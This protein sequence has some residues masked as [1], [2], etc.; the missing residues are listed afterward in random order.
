M[1]TEYVNKTVTNIEYS[2]LKI[3]VLKTFL[4]VDDNNIKKWLYNQAKVAMKDKTADAG[5]FNLQY[6]HQDVADRMN[7]RKWIP[8]R[9]ENK[10]TAQDLARK[11][12]NYTNWVSG[13]LL[14]TGSAMINYTQT[15]SMVEDWGV[16]LTLEAFN[17]A[18]TQ[19]AKDAVLKSGTISLINAYT[20]FMAGGESGGNMN[21]ASKPSTVVTATFNWALLKLNKSD[22]INKNTGIDKIL[23]NMLPEQDR[24]THEALR[25]QRA[26]FYDQMN[27]LKKILK[28]DKSEIRENDIRNAKISAKELR[29][30]KKR[31]KNLNGNLNSSQINQLASWM[32]TWHWNETLENFTFS[33]AELNMR[34][35]TT[36]Q[37]FI[38][39]EKFGL[40]N[41]DSNTPLYQ[42][43]PSLMMGRIN[44]YNTMFG[45]AREFFPKMFGGYWG[46][47]LL[48]FKT[49]TFAEFVREHNAVEAFMMS[50]DGGVWNVPGWSSRIVK[51]LFKK[52]KR[53]AKGEGFRG[54]ADYIDLM[55]TDP[56]FDLSAERFFNLMIIR[57][58]LSF[59]L[60]GAFFSPG[61]AALSSVTKRLGMNL[62]V[63]GGSMRGVQS[64]YISTAL[65]AAILLATMT[66][67]DIPDEDKEKEFWEE[68]RYLLFPVFVNAII[69]LTQGDFQRAM[70]PY[71]RFAKQGSNAHKAIA[72]TLD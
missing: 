43:P 44:T 62:G 1:Y 29:I 22:F 57:G 68:W 47:R 4:S 45:M 71:V 42:Q 35:W 64:I 3:E 11:T 31:I 36:V 65:K 51:T 9:S 30:L 24:G 14:D 72:P 40:L 61:L 53:T 34:T 10:L 15:L 23:Q 19:E 39:S 66:G 6:G 48:Q 13:N 2:K 18:K 41:A 54:K 8:W 5:F 28:R 69:S 21:F 56:T 33:G 37:G 16:S 67:S 70:R 7:K 58:A 46:P 50:N 20:D 59:I 52:I 38:I 26:A 55:F 25:R 27:Y 32:L 63:S 60:V 17:V 49:Y 12:S